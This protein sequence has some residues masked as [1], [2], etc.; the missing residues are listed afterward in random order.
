MAR[1]NK[2]LAMNRLDG[3]ESLYRKM[4]DYFHRDYRNYPERI[5]SLIASRDNE[6]YVLTHSLKNIA[7]S[8]GAEDLSEKALNL[9]KLLKEG[10]FEGTDSLLEVLLEEFEPVK[11]LLDEEEGVVKTE[12]KSGGTG[13][14]DL[15]QMIDGLIDAMGSFSPDKAEEA[16]EK[17]SLSY[18]LIPESCSDEFEDILALAR[19]YRFFD[20]EEKLMDLKKRLK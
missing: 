2:T 3:D 13:W 11:A 12:E 4:L 18:S 6:A 5:Q 15:T 14:T 19:D 20:A 1:M 8:L 16:L 10:I 7:A 9:E 17:A